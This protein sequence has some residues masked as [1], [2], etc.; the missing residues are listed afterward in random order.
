MYYNQKVTGNPNFWSTHGVIIS[1]W[2]SEGGGQ[3]G[4][5]TP[6]PERENFRCKT[7]Q[8]SD[9]QNA[10]IFRERVAELMKRFS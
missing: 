1:K 2:A 5:S 9:P 8:F 10:Q 6:D 4:L 3:E 7:Y